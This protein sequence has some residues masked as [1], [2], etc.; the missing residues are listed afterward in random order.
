[1]T[2]PPRF[3]KRPPIKAVPVAAVFYLM[4]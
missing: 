4:T 1:L 2:Y 3:R